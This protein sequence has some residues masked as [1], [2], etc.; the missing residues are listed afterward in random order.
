MDRGADIE[1]YIRALEAH[2]V[3][4]GWV[5]LVRVT[6]DEPAD[7]QRYRASLARLRTV[8]PR[9]KLKAALNHAEFIRKFAGEV[10]DY[11]PLLS[12][13][14]QEWEAVQELR[15]T[16][17]GRF[18][19]YVCCAPAYPNNWIKSPLV[20]S[21]LLL[22]LV[23]WARLDGFLRWDFT[24]WPARPRERAWWRWVAGDT[25]FVLPGRDGRPLLTLRYQALQRGTQDYELAQMVRRRGSAGE[26]VLAEIHARLLPVASPGQLYP[27]PPVAP[28]ELYSLQHEDYE[29]ARRKM[30][31]FLAS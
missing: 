9:L 21:R 7:E 23:D 25:H 18:S 24:A 28:G 10:E 2:F 31:E 26:Q 20:E 12:C 27:E 16:L 5:D 14:A 6:A 29:W 19:F 22:W 13:V 11:V 3:E 4:R 30:L 8:A 17:P 1:A 15:R